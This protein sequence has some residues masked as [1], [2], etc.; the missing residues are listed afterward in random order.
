M[1]CWLDRA[2]QPTPSPLLGELSF[3]V[4]KPLA[5]Q[6]PSRHLCTCDPLLSLNCLFRTPW[7]DLKASFLI[8]LPGSGLQRARARSYA[9]PGFQGSPLRLG[10]QPVRLEARRV[11][12]CPDPS[13]GA[14]SVA[15]AQP[16]PYLVTFLSSC[17]SGEGL[18][19]TRR[20]SLR[21]Q[22]EAKMLIPSG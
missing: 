1:R 6:R 12:R 22:P 13:P 8:F 20:S 10:C 15:P 16:P 21:T 18:R 4:Y 19:L 11:P 3:R 5:F 14:N 7:P 17:R 2:P 9:L